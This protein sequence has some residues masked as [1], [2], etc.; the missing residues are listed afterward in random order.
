LSQRPEACE[1]LPLPPRKGRGYLARHI[2]PSSKPLVI[3]EAQRQVLCHDHAA[4]AISMYVNC[5]VINATAYIHP[6]N[7]A[8][9]SP[10]RLAEP[11]ADLRGAPEER[12]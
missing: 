8:S 5:C 7:G 3:K 2:R 11:P 4:F 10:A 1:I 6:R 9:R 12:T